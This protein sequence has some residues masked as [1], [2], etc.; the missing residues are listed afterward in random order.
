MSIDK[1][2]ASV[3]D[4]S[5]LDCWEHIIMQLITSMFPAFMYMGFLQIG[6][7]LA[8]PFDESF[9]PG[10]S[11]IPTR[12]LISQLRGDLAAAEN[13]NKAIEGWAAPSFKQSTAPKPAA[14]AAPA[15]PAK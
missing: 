12:R 10:L 5:T 2:S 4:D 7:T 8:Q 1:V 15:A 9:G 6:L 11:A 3:H 14:P 13:M